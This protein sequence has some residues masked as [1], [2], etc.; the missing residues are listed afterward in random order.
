[1][2]RFSCLMTCLLLAAAPLA[3]FDAAAASFGAAKPVVAPAAAVP[4]AAAPAAIEPI[5]AIDIPT[6]A[7]ADERFAQDSIARARQ[8]DPADKLAPQLD[9]MAIAVRKLS[10]TFK[11]DELQSLPAIRLQ[12]LERHW[13]FYDTGLAAWRGQLQRA[14]ARYSEDVAELA[15]KRA[16]WEATR[17]TGVALP[18]ALSER[19]DSII[20][21]I[22]L[23]EQALS[24]PLDKQLRLAR[25][26][27]S[28]QQA[29]DSGET[30]VA[31]AIAYFDRRLLMADSPPLW[32]EWQDWAPSDK[33]LSTLLVGLEIERDFLTEYNAAYKTRLLAL[34]VAA[35]LLLPFFIWLSRRSRN[36][37][38]DDPELVSS[39][40]VLLRPI[41]SWLVVVL[42]GVLFFEPHAPIIRHQAALLLALVPVLRLLPRKVYAVLGPWPY[43][44]T[45]LYLLQQL[46][47]LFVAVPLML[48]LHLLVIGALS[49]M[50]VLWLLLRRK[51]RSGEPGE[52]R[53]FAVVRVFGWASV[54]ALLAALVANLMGNV[55]LAEM[56]TGGVLDSGYV[57]LALYAGASVLNAILALL[58]ARRGLTRFHAVTRHAGPLLQVVGR[59]VN[60]AAFVAWVVVVLNQFRLYRPLEHWARVVLTYPIGIGAISITLGSVVLFLAS[61]WVAV[62]L[63]RTIRVV[64]RDEVLPKM[65]LPRGVGNSVSTLTYYGVLALGVTTALA[66]AGFHLSELA[67]IVGALGVGIGFGL[68]DVV[69]NFV[70]GL[71]LMFERPIQPGD[72]IEVSG[73]SGKVREIGMRATTLTTFEGADVVVPNGTLLSEKLINWTLSDMNRRLDVNV[74]V[75]YGVDPKR[76]LTLLQAVATATPGVAADPPPAV[77]FS[78]FG[79]SSL[80]FG[81]RAW[82]DNFADW[83]AIRSA[84]TVRVY[85]ALVEAGISIPFPQ[86][87]LHLKSVSPEALAGL[88]GLGRGEAG[89]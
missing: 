24:G 41:S 33:S 26:G 75:A 88:G 39:A 18:P 10:E 28:V 19:I 23:A 31:S 69:K 48:R 38:S 36:L 77:I 45:A 73:T 63:A 66:A 4:A 27:N 57:G 35:L 25:R 85:D 22:A 52:P 21:E 60:V 50:T 15:R 55:S 1:M 17:T 13:K 40:Q 70:S 82:T 74:G 12:S 2:R 11:R 5:A 89:A 8:A 58:L 56:L 59:L 61:V 20:A 86:H 7:D 78:G 87:D 81:L 71:I 53:H 6:R 54:A 32:E 65:D 72:V 67:F 34:R 68:Q 79:P 62:W 64:L 9:A 80:D 37:V 49:L 83:V 14:T 46:G 44:V 3:G 16:S 51:G 76:V 42:V 84:L 29:V 43:I 30:A 47:F